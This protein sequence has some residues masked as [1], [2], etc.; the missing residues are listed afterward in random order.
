MRK[1][2]WALIGVA[3]ILAGGLQVADAAVTC[4]FI[5]GWCPDPDKLDKDH[6]PAPTPT[7]VPEPAMLMLLGAGV[8]AVGVA[9]LRR[10]KK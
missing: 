8:S 2:S 1:A 6:K 10:R 9:A 7:S 3:A 4:K 5:Q